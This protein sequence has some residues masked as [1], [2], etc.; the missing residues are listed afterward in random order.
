MT[1]FLPTAGHFRIHSHAALWQLCHTSSRVC[2]GSDKCLPCLQPLFPSPA[3]TARSLCRSERIGAGAVADES[4]TSKPSKRSSLLATVAALLDRAFDRSRYQAQ[5]SLPIR[6]WKPCN[7]EP[8]ILFDLRCPF[9]MCLRTCPTS[10]R[11]RVSSFCAQGSFGKASALASALPR[12]TAPR[13]AAA[14]LESTSESSGALASAL[15]ACSPEMEASWL[16]GE[17]WPPWCRPP[18]A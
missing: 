12:M 5:I 8:L 13:R 10:Q 17:R 7:W 6:N 16:A 18:A 9:L 15:E 11:G 3:C 4:K 2:R 1:I 14:I